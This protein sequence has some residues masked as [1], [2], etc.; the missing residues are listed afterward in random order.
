MRK[1]LVRV[2]KKFQLQLGVPK[3]VRHDF[4]V[5]KKTWMINTSD[6]R[7]AELIADRHEREFRAQVLQSKQNALQGDYLDPKRALMV[8]GWLLGQI[9]E[10]PG[11]EFSPDLDER[12]ASIITVA[13]YDG[14]PMMQG[15]HS[16]GVVFEQIVKQVEVLLETSER[17]QFEKTR[18]VKPPSQTLLDAWEA[19]SKIAKQRP[20]T[21]AMYGAEARKFSAWFA[22]SYGT[23]YGRAITEQHV[24]L[25]ADHL[26]ERGLA[27]ATINHSLSALRLVFKAGRF[28]PKNPFAGVHDRLIISGDR[29]EV[30]AFTPDEMR[31]LLSTN[32]EERTAVLIAAYSGMRCGEIASLKV[33]H[34]VKDPTSDVTC[35]D[36]TAAGQRKTKASYRQVPVHPRLMR[37]VVD[38]L[39]GADPEQRLVPCNASTLSTKLNRLIDTVT[40]DPAVR[41]HSFRH[42]FITRMA[43]NGTDPEQRKLIV[44]HTGAGVHARYTHAERLAELAREIAKVRYD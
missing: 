20:K 15:V 3:A 44:G 27:R 31:R 22:R 39:R 14:H 42:G 7:E 28:A 23:A 18:K 32:S 36:L 6:E 10:D 11:G 21:I 4:G 37:D 41:A 33:K 2:G 12:L 40:E 43:E 1:G 13:Q 5:Q 9:Q 34:I 8:T 38:P 19:W 35:F 25:Y 16:A 17:G 26:M 24:N 29:L 30:R